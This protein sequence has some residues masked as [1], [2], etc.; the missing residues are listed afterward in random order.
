M[1]GNASDDN[2][3]TE[4]HWEFELDRE[5]PE[6]ELVRAIAAFEGKDTVELSPLYETINDLVEKLY[7]NPPRTDAEARLEF[8]YEGYRVVL[9]QDGHA[10]VRKVA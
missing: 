5:A 4:D 9:T 7:T 6:Y 3:Q 10:S 1:T 2:G 8:T